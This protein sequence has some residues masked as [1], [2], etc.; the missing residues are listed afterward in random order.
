MFKTYEDLI[1]GLNKNVERITSEAYDLGLQVWDYF[2]NNL[3]EKV[4]QNDNKIIIIKCD[5]C[6]YLQDDGEEVRCINKDSNPLY[7]FDEDLIGCE[8]GWEAGEVEEVED[9]NK[10]CKNCLCSMYFVLGS[11][12]CTRFD[13]INNCS[14]CHTFN[15]LITEKITFKEAVDKLT[16]G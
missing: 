3:N 4:R 13:D 14:T 8:A 7:S 2:I 5:G 1:V 12:N 11:N 16:R 9:K 15:E 10:E 6:R